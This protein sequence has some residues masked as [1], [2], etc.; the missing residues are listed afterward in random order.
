ML[1]SRMH[2]GIQWHT[3]KFLV[4]KK[5]FTTT[6]KSVSACNVLLNS[7]KDRLMLR[8]LLPS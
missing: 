8:E 4:C 3:W 2:A 1:L 5:P 6:R 7:C